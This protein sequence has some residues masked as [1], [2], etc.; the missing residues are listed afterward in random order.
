MQQLSLKLS[1]CLQLFLSLSLTSLYMSSCLIMSYEAGVV[2]I[3]SN[4]SQEVF[5]SVSFK[6]RVSGSQKFP[7]HYDLPLT[8]YGKDQKP[9]LMDYILG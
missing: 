1:V 8:Q 7:L 2:W 5:T 6:D 3:P 4:F 9:W